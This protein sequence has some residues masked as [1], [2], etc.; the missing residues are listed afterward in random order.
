MQEGEI[1]I[2]TDEHA[3]GELEEL[4]AV[5]LFHIKVAKGMAELDDID[6]VVRPLRSNIHDETEWD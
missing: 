1:K 5:C 4:C 6:E 3:P 2:R